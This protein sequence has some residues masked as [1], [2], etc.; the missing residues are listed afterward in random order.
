MFAANAKGE[1]CTQH[2]EKLSMYKCLVPVQNRLPNAL[3]KEVGERLKNFRVTAICGEISTIPTI[4]W[5]LLT[6]SRYGGV[7]QGFQKQ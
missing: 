4:K 6:K 5:C 3:G 7:D 2:L 1:Q